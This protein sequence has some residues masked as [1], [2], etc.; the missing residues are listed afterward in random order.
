[1]EETQTSIWKSRKNSTSD[2]EYLKDGVLITTSN[3]FKIERTIMSENTARFTLAHRSLLLQSPLIDK[4]SLFAEKEAGQQIISQ[5]AVKFE[6]E[7]DLN[8]LLSLFYKYKPT[9]IPFLG[10]VT[11]Q[12][13]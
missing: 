5:G 1:M 2:V 4:I 12:N 10:I 9:K 8:A 11:W 6:G 7:S 3:K 13:H